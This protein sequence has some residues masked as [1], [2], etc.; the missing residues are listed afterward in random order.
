ML[1]DKEQPYWLAELEELRSW[2]ER[3]ENGQEAMPE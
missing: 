3:P 2:E 1:E